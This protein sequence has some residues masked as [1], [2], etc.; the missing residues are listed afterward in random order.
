MV[1]TTKLLPSW[2]LRLYVT[3]SMERRQEILLSYSL[4][5]CDLATIIAAIYNY[6]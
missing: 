3:I 2:Y 5:S 6:S 1:M 4:Y